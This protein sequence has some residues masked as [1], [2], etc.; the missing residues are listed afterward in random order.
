MKVIS[1]L[2]PWATF[3]VMGIKKFETRSFNTKFRGKILIHASKKF[4]K[5]QFDLCFDIPEF[6]KHFEE[7]STMDLPKGFIIGSV[8][9]TDT[10]PTWQVTHYLNIFDSPLSEFKGLG[11][12]QWKEEIVY[13]DYSNER[14]AWKLENAIQFANP[15]PAKGQL[16]FWNY[17]M[18]DHF[19]IPIESGGHSTFP[20][21]P[22]K[23]T[24]DAVNAMVELAKKKIK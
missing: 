19:H 23:D 18:P 20:S 12:R 16:G 17:D 9:I 21:P 5:H 11:P 13:G 15:I 1:L 24:L 22:D 10:I 6:R 7:M 2:Q 14:F 8:E 4:S 3:V